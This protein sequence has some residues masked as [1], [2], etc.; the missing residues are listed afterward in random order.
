MECL[1]KAVGDKS[2][3][4]ADYCYYF[5][6]IISNCLR[7]AVMK[8]RIVFS[9]FACTLGCAITAFAQNYPTRSVSVVVPFPAGGPTDTIARIMAERMT[10]S[11]TQTVLVEN[12]AGAGGTI[13]AGKVA[14]A[15]PDGYTV[16]IGHIG[17]HVINGAIYQLPYD[18]FKDFAPVALV[19]SNPQVLVSKNAV[20]AKDLK[21][22]IAW[23]KANEKKATIATGS[24]G[25]PSHVSGVYFQKVTNSQ[26][27]IVHYRGGAPAMQDVLGGQIDL[28]F[29]QAA[30]ALPQV[31]SG[32]VRAYAVT[33]KSRLSA[34]PEI[35]TVDEAGLA[36]FYMAVW[37]GMWLP[38]GVPAPVVTRLNTAITEALAD[39]GVRQRLAELGQEIPPREQ[40]TPEGLRTHHKAEN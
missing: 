40:Q 18:V 2:R 33:A 36:G 12:S 17:T 31:R 4:L 24:S 3:V 28:F 23:V 27:Q 20:A 16:A 37:H 29:D 6:F 34:A 10:R 1:A 39:S 22:L 13:G 14:R 11:L 38:N 5:K 8:N 30:T 19:A 15:A 7:S 25:T 9:V 35:P 32:K 26:P 21:E